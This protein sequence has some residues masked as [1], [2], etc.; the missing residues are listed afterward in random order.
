[1]SKLHPRP[2]RLIPPVLGSLLALLVLSACDILGA[3]NEI[4]REARVLVSGSASNELLVVT[5]NNFSHVPDAG[6]NPVVVLQNSD[7]VYIDP[8]AVHDEIYDIAPANAFYAE[9]TNPDTTTAIVTMRVWV[10]GDL[11]YEQV[12]F[13]LVDQSLSFSRSYNDFGY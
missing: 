9:L 6:G 13:T 5:S 4:P 1:M 12:D 3:D 7:T 8:A 2:A 10:D 11:E